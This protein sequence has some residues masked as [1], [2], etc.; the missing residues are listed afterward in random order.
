MPKSHKK[1]FLII[2]SIVIALLSLSCTSDKITEHEPQDWTS[3]ELYAKLNEDIKNE[4]LEEFLLS[5]SEYDLKT[6]FHDRLGNRFRFSF[7]YEKINEFKFLE[8]LIGA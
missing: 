2:I 7:D 4:A 3:G 1:L 8:R 6:I 5:Y